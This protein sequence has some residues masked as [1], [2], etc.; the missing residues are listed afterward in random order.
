MDKIGKFEIVKILG[1]GGMGVVYKGRD[2]FIE[3]DVA[4]KVILE[5]ALGLP[6]IK[7]RFYREARSAGKLSHENITVVY[8]VGEVDGNPYIVMEYL[9]G[10]ELKKIITNKRDIPLQKKIS[11]AIQICKGLHYAHSKKIVHRD[12]KPDNIQIL[13]DGK[14]KIMDFGIA[15]PEAS[16]LTRTGIMVGTLAY[17]SPEQIKGTKIDNRSD[18]FSF[19][20]LFYELLTYKRPFVGDSTTIM[21]KIVHDEPEKME[22]Q[23]DDLGNLLQ[24]ILMKCLQKNRDDR[25][26]NC[27]EIVEDLEKLISF[28]GIQQSIVELLDQGKTLCQQRRPE[29]VEKFDEILNLDPEHKEAKRLKEECLENIDD[30]KTVL[31]NRPKIKPAKVAVKKVVAKPQTPPR[32]RSRKGVYVFMVLLLLAAGSFV[33]REQLKDFIEQAAGGKTKI[34]AK[35]SVS[36][37]TVKQEMI[38]AKSLAGQS[39]ASINALEVFRVAVNFEDRAIKAE[40][41]GNFPEAQS[42]F[43]QAGVK[44]AEAAKAAAKKLDL[45]SFERSATQARQSALRAEKKALRNGAKDMASYKKA[46][47][48]LASA[49]KEFRQGKYELAGSVFASAESFFNRAIKEAADLRR[50]K[51]SNQ[52]LISEVN[53]AKEETTQA[54][55]EADRKNAKSL[56]REA[57]DFASGKESEGKN[58]LNKK[59]YSRAIGSFQDATLGYR[60]AFREKDA[61]DKAQKL[62]QKSDYAQSLKE[63]QAVFVSTPYNGEN[64]KARKLYTDIQRAQ[65][66]FSQKIE[67]AKSAS[68]REDLTAALAFLNALPARDKEMFEVRNL[69]KTIIAKDQTPPVIQHTADK[70]YDPQEPIRISATVQDNLEINLVTLYYVKKGTKTYSRGRMQT[71]GRGSYDFMIPQEY[72]KGKE[73]KY[74]FAALDANSNKKNLATQK[75]PYKIKSKSKKANIPQIP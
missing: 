63:L 43:A 45:A 64:K 14:A 68:N 2:P 41:A 38:R 46:K 65:F 20:V 40:K 53:D 25:Y 6:E 23:E 55:S 70:D 13:K 8:E 74:Y 36:L 66:N 12:I 18:I 57:Y 44:Y 1:K 37:E 24:E 17:M 29:A 67:D 28:K 27:A 35:A 56:A 3:R 42:L 22:L 54:K 30:V 39:Q 33:F 52:Q 69:K 19:G 26:R 11:Y 62:F 47:N 16:T 10:E 48:F 51:M 60:T 59:R 50:K 4:I 72:H 75:K 61:A 5:R 15:K 21:Y 34:A 31:L 58:H 32:K 71:K 49:G 73:I 9:E 7:E